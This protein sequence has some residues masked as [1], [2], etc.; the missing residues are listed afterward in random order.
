MRRLAE[1][2]Y[3][4]RSAASAPHHTDDVLASNQSPEGQFFHSLDVHVRLLSTLII[5]RTVNQGL[6]AHCYIFA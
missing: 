6:W 5:L 2:I 4:S 1:E 3:E